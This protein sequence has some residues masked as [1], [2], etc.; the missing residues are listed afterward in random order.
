MRC[1]LR[2]FLLPVP[3]IIPV[4][5]AS[6]SQHQKADI[7]DGEMRQLDLE[8]ASRKVIVNSVGTCSPSHLVTA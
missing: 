7:I 1:S 3:T 4:L 8:R 5:R 6:L 2:H